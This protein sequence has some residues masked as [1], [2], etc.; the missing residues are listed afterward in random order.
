M[1]RPYRPDDLPALQEITAAC[2]ERVSVDRN[3]EL[4]LGPVGG[5]DWRWRKARHIAADVAGDNARGVLVA[6]IDGQVAGYV[7]CRT[8]PESRFGWI[9]NLAV[10][11]ELQ[12]QGLGRQLLEAAL[13]WLRQAGMEVARIETLE[14]NPIGPHLYPSLGFREV[15]RQIHYVMPL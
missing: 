14:Q 5:H 4:M 3:I 1:I 15:A 9:P 13:D 6:E 2:F 11:P 7:T 8:D 12:G 10:R